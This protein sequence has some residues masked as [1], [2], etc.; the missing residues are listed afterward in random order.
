MRIADDKDD[1]NDH[2]DDDDKRHRSKKREKPVNLVCRP[3]RDAKRKCDEQEPCGRCVA[4]GCQHD[5]VRVVLRKKGRPRKNR[6]DEQ[7]HQQPPPPQQQQ[8]HQQELVVVP[9]A[10]INQRECALVLPPWTQAELACP[11]MLSL[12]MTY[13][14][15][16]MLTE[17]PRDVAL[18]IGLDVGTN[19]I[20]AS[21][22]QLHRLAT[23]ADAMR[24]AHVVSAHADG[25]CDDFPICALVGR[26]LF[27][28]D[29][30]GCGDHRLIEPF[31]FASQAQ[32]PQVRLITLRKSV[33]DKY[34]RT[35]D[36]SFKLTAFLDEAGQPR[37]LFCTV[38]DIV[39][40]S[41]LRD[42]LTGCTCVSTSGSASPSVCGSFRGGSFEFDTMVNDADDDM[43][44][45]LGASSLLPWDDMLLATP[46]LS[47]S[48]SGGA[49]V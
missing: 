43:M 27:D 12:L 34:G 47:G 36:A 46:T 2:D 37:W 9:P 32:Q 5:C 14:P 30:P 35:V 15:L 3:C 1:N 49:L 10:T 11:K 8:Q 39:P 42:E 31:L 44:E 29:V 40:V 33:F 24:S 28:I 4:K 26:T 48:A 6:S 7:Q 13:A 16:Q 20:V 21:F 22:P 41:P 25:T 23:R 18:S 17:R 38:L 45:L 19:F